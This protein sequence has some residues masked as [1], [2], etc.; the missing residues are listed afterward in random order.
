[1]TSVRNSA[2]AGIVATSI[3]GGNA[4]PGIL[5]FVALAV[6]SVAR[7][8][9]LGAMGPFDRASGRYPE[10]APAAR[11]IDAVQVR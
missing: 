6:V 3:S 9:A 8:R 5:F 10:T 1:V 7:V 4:D 11:A 2:L